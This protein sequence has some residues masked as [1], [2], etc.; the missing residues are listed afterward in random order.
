[1]VPGIYKH[2]KGK[3]YRVFWVSKHSE[4]GKL[5]VVYQTLYAGNQYYHRSL[6]MF[7]ETVIVDEVEIPRFTF[8]CESFETFIADTLLA[9]KL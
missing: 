5:D 6:E 3:Y 8:V 9:Y 7:L 4:T 1:M 2:Y